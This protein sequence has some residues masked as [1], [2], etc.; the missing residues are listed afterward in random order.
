MKTKLLRFALCLIALI[1]LLFTLSGAALADDLEVHFMN[2]GRNDGIL[3]LCGEE[4]VFIDS[5]TYGRGQLAAE[6]IRSLGMSELTYYIGT[7]AHEDHVGGASVIIEAF[8]PRKVIQPHA[9]VEKLI[10]SC[11][12]T[13][14]ERAAVRGTEFVCMTPGQVL[15]V[16]S[17]TLTCLGPLTIR[18][19]SVQDSAENANSLVL[20]LTLG[21]IDILLTGDATNGSLRAIEAANPGILRAD[22]LKNAH[23][24]GAI[25]EDVLLAVDPEYIIYSTDDDYMPERSTLTLMRNEHITVLATAPSH[26]GTII[27]RTDGREIDFEV[28]NPPEVLTF[29]SSEVSLYEGAQ[30]AVN[31][32]HRPSKRWKILLYESS[33]PSVAT[34]SSSGTIT[35]VKAGDAIIRVMD[36]SGVYAECTVTVLPATLTLKKTALTVKDS[37]SVTAGYS[38]SPSASKAKPVWASLNEEIATVDQKGRITG[39]HPGE[40]IITATMPSGAV[41][42][43]AVTV[44]PVAVSSVS[45]S[46]SSLTMTI[47][48]SRSVSAKISPSNASYKDVVWSSADESI[49]TVSPEGMVQAVGVGKTK[50]TATAA[51][52]R[53]RTISVTVKPLYIKKITLPQSVVSLTVGAEGHESAQLLHAIEPLNATT[54]KVTWSSSNK[55]I[56][57]VDENGVVTAVK[58]GSVTITCKAAD[59]SGK[60][61]KLKVNVEAP[62]EQIILGKTSLSIYEGTT[63]S[64][65]VTI[66]PSSKTKQ[67]FYESSDPSVAIVSDSGKITGI[68]AGE[69]VIRVKDALGVYAECTVSVQTTVMTLRQTALTVKDGARVSASWRMNPS[70]AKPALVW[71]SAD[72]SIAT[73]DTSG[74]ITGQY[75]GQTE[76]YVQM[77]GGQV[78]VLS[79]TVTP[80][81]VSSVSIQPSSV[82][83]TL[84]ENKALKASVSPS[85]ATWPEVSWSSADESIVLVDENGAVR[86][87][88]VGKTKITASTADGKARSISV[89]VKPVY[90]KKITIASVPYRL[91]GGAAGRNQVQLSHTIEPANATIQD[92]VWSSSN[93]KIAVVDQNG[94]VTGLKEG[95]VTITCKATDGSSRYARIKL[96]FDKNEMTHKVVSKSGE[97]VSETSV[98]RYR[99]NGGTLEVEMTYINR[100]GATLRI[101]EQGLLILVLPDDT[102]IPLQPVSGSQKSIKHSGVER[103]T[104]RISTATNPRLIGLD[105]TRCNAII[106]THP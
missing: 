71:S 6:Y 93:Q 69:A 9:Q 74:R 34:V 90:V 84:G 23:H 52:G 78:H 103:L 27:L 50:L 56:A 79:V 48:D 53:S 94:V 81:K 33:D 35:G 89:T 67:L 68:R 58:P 7:H 15:H 99:D 104:Y 102:R 4:S 66:K 29:A 32:T 77:P 82:T 44:T 1:G 73:V 24:H 30:T 65:K 47:Y 46:P 41:S 10:Y 95:T 8:R 11:A 43:I 62:T 45:I 100:T 14:E 16:G 25:Y 21:D 63:A 106:D 49:L 60:Y 96:T 19:A 75:P 59:G 57:T 101:P 2:I 55:K 86:S 80:I 13:S 5:G 105:L 31:V 91:I 51:N 88:G 38:I 70:A 39:V 85:N 98:I 28:D 36:G 76:I 26:C 12:V 97:L 3:I 18:K 37:A 87:V 20:R 42:E 92:V 61:A 83:L 54:P 17:A 40:A 22:V 72:E 64:I